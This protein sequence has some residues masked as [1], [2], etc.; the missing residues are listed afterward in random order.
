MRQDLATRSLMV[1]GEIFTVIH[2]TEDAVSAYS[3]FPDI[4][5][6]SDFVG[7]T[8][9]DKATMRTILGFRKLKQDEIDYLL[10]L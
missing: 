7:N 5:K 9:V 1:D 4:N 2:H 3:Y 8:P 10:N 6:V